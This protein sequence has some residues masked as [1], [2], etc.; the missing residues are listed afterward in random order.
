MV[1]LPTH[2]W[3]KLL[4]FRDT[5]FYQ[6]VERDIERAIHIVRVC[7]WLC[8]C[9]VLVFSSNVYTKRNTHTGLL[10]SAFEKY[11]FFS[12]CRN[13]TGYI[14]FL[15]YYEQ[16][17]CVGVFFRLILRLL[18]YFYTCGILDYLR[19]CVCVGPA[20]TNTCF[21]LTLRRFV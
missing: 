6:C 16:L 8:L 9:I 13:T 5:L 17:L 20:Y 14:T 11:S 1:L 3:T 7:V 18:Y 4:T 21:N 2:Y 12:N 19:I 10:H 15:L